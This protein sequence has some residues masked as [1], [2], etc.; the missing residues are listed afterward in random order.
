M[1]RVQ[2]LAPASI[3]VLLLFGGCAALEWHKPGVTAEQRDRDVA[4]CTE[5]ARGEAL[6]HASAREPVPRIIVDQQGR[7]AA[8]RETHHDAERFLLEQDLLRAC[9]RERGYALQERAT[10]VH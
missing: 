1:L 10:G 7:A 3:A 6:R 9:L 2:T 4:A 8:V 5:K